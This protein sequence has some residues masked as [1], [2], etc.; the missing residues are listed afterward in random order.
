MAIWRP[1]TKFKLKG[2]FQVLF[3]QAGAELMLGGG[4]A[5]AGQASLRQAQSSQRANGRHS[6]SL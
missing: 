6:R 1:C 2:I 4:A 5:L 3:A